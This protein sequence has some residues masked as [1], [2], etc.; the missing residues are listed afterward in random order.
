MVS[1]S[2]RECL[3]AIKDRYRHAGRKYKKIILDEDLRDPDAIDLE[4]VR[5]ETTD[6]EQ[7]D[8]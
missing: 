7:E 4:E 3:A 1:R 5:A 2:K 8:K 6:L